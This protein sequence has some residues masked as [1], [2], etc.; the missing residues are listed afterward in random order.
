MFSGE[1]LEIEMRGVLQGEDKDQLLSETQLEQFTDR[2]EKSF[3]ERRKF[4]QLEEE[5][6]DD[7]RRIIDRPTRTF[8]VTAVSKA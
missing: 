7:A 4:Q 8:C 6:E 1:P 5:E 2:E 3:G